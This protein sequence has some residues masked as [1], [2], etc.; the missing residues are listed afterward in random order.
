M[1]FHTI[2]IGVWNLTGQRSHLLPKNSLNFLSKYID[3]TGS[4]Q[5]WDLFAN[6]LYNNYQAIMVCDTITFPLSN[7]HVECIGN[8]LYK[9]YEGSLDSINLNRGNLSRSYR[10]AEQF[11]ATN[12]EEAY[13]SFLRS[14]EKQTPNSTT[15][16]LYLILQ[17]KPSNKTDGLI[18]KQL[19]W[20]V[21]RS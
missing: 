18:S 12:N 3:F 9:S 11:I 17:I 2:V 21:K 14:F 7:Q 16:Y 5:Y 13:E 15:P 19:M 20:V 8:I 1:I 4:E 6:D 10:F